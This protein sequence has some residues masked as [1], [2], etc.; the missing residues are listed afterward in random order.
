MGLASEEIA[1]TWGGSAITKYAIENQ[2]DTK[3]TK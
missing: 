3:G 2:N 1:V